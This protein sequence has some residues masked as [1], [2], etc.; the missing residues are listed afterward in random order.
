MIIVGIDEVGRGALAGPVCV[1]VFVVDESNSL[2]I[3]DNAPYGITD[4]KQITEKRRDVLFQYFL[5]CKKEKL[6]DFVIMSMGADKIDTFGISVCIKQM[7]EKGLE[8]LNLDTKSTLVLLDGGLK[9]PI[10]YDQKTII[11]GD[12]TEFAISCA[13]IVAK[14]Y[15]DEHMKKQTHLYPDYGFGKHVG[16]GTQLHR[17]MIK[18]YGQSLLHRKT[19]CKNIT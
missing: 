13:S 16:Y 5:K 6:C 11:K 8:K 9:A 7:I 18:K 3:L 10:A 1:G 15:R 17:D 4:S 14:V 19:F 12:V 2:K